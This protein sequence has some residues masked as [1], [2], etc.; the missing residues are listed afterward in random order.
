MAAFWPGPRADA[1]RAW[2]APAAG[3]GLH[4]ETW[5]ELWWTTRS[6][7]RAHHPSS[8]RP[9]SFATTSCLPSG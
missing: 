3:P 5:V 2:V 8:E 1:E 6:E 9:R 4:L 7:H